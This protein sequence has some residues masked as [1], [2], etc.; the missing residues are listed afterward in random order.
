MKSLE[1]ALGKFVLRK[2]IIL[3]M[4]LIHYKLLVYMNNLFVNQTNL[5]VLYV[6]FCMQLVRTVQKKGMFAFLT[7]Y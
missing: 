7:F 6:F 4:F 1:L 2:K 3:I 5:V